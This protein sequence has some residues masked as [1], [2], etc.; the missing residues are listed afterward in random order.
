MIASYNTR[1]VKARIGLFL[2]KTRCPYPSPYFARGVG[3]GLSMGFPDNISKRGKFLKKLW[4]CVGGTVLQD[5]F[6]FFN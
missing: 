3:F 5:N 6:F 2:N 4:C 1:I